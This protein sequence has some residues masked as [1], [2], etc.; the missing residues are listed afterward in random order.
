M[1]RVRVRVGLRIRV[2][3]GLLFNNIRRENERGPEV[4]EDN[5]K[6]LWVSVDEIR[7]VSLGLSE[8]SQE[9][10]EVGARKAKQS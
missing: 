8:A 4:V 10:N 5:V 9:T 6:A 2:R 7:S 1:M 3:C